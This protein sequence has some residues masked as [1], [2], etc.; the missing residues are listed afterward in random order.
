MKKKIDELEKQ[1]ADKQNQYLRALADYQNL[2][3]RI[4][5]EQKQFQQKQLFAFL[6]KLIEIK[7]D[8]DKAAI[9]NKDNGLKL[10]LNKVNNL[11]RDYS[12]TEINPL[13]QEFSPQTMEC[14]QTEEGQSHNKVIKVLSKG[15]LWNKELLKPAKVVVSQLKVS[16]KKDTGHTN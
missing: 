16:P 3:K 8:M 10:I 5:Q 7:E 15:Y 4:N 14:I 6:H 9:F 2:E 13:H 12:V 11:L 1:L